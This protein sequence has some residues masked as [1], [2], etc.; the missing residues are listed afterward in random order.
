MAGILGSPR[1]LP[2]GYPLVGGV[3]RRRR[4]AIAIEFMIGFSVFVIAF[5]AVTYALIAVRGRK[6]HERM[7][8]HVRTQVAPRLLSDG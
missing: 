2:Y 7:L 4:G 8:H 1:P 3:V 5:S 6:A